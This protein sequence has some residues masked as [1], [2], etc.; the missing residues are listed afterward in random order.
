LKEI[1]TNHVPMLAPLG[2]LKGVDCKRIGL[3]VDTCLRHAEILQQSLPLLRNKVMEVFKPYPPTGTTDPDHMI[4][5]G[6]FF[7][8]HDRMLMNKIRA[9]D[10]SQLGK[11]NWR[12]E[13][14]RLAEM[15]FRY[16]ARNYPDTMTAQEDKQWRNDR[17]LR[18]TQPEDIR[19]LTPESFKQELMAARQT[20]MGDYRTQGVLDQLEAWVDVV[21]KDV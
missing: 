15:L 13:D 12:F 4:Y 10:P 9:S 18:L 16:R 8:N 20:S 17:K 2:T 1:K 14:N 19:Q 6:G 3:D 21:C 7:S 5:S 11:A